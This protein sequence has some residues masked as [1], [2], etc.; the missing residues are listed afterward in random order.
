MIDTETD[1][2]EEREYYI[3]V[4]DGVRHLQYSV[5]VPPDGPSEPLALAQQGNSEKANEPHVQPTQHDSRWGEN[6]RTTGMETQRKD[7]IVKNKAKHNIPT[8]S[9]PFDVLSDPHLPYHDFIPGTD[10]E[11]DDKSVNPLPT[12]QPKTPKRTRRKPSRRRSSKAT[13]SEND[14]DITDDDRDLSM[15]RLSDEDSDSSLTNHL[16][17]GLQQQ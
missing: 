8:H 10:T 3:E 12:S 9:N 7:G 13:G 14:D 15:Y 2:E 4:I 17:Q 5:V 6:T 1:V 16:L 11:D